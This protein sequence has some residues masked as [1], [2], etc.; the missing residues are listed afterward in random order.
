MKF[1][2]NSTFKMAISATIA[3]FIAQGF[4]LEFAVTAG[5]I[6]I[7]SIQNTKREALIIG[8][9]RIISATIAVILS[10]L[11]YVLL[12][13]NPLV[14]GIVLLIFIPIAKKLKIEEGIAVG[15]VLS[16]H[17]LVNNNIDLGWIVNEEAITFIGIGVAS[18]FNLYMPS[19]DDKFNENKETIEKLYR[20]IISD[21]AKSLV[22]KA[23]PV[24]EKKRLEEVESLVED[25]RSLAYKI[26]NNNLFKKNLYFVDYIEMR[27][28]QLEAIKR[29]MSHFSRFSITYDQTLI[30]SKFTENIANN[31]YADNDCVELIC[32]LNNLRNNY[33][34]MQLPKT[35]D[36]FENRA[37]LFQFL[38]DLEDFLLIKKEFK[39]TY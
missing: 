29:M 1:F 35:R 16:T 6:A 14:F 11:L 27:S 10:Y 12:G 8:A 24:N 20:D 30:M 37:M 33:K 18:L 5:V 3:I 32:K 4:K 7:L 23:I 34:E 26:N 13:N 17:L 9:R 38:N 2:N 22:T 21:M 36:E 28:K 39:K 15:A 19:L 31:I 25:T